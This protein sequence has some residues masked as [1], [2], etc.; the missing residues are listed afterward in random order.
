MKNWRDTNP[1]ARKAEMKYLF[2]IGLSPV[3]FI[4][5]SR[6][7]K[8]QVKAYSKGRWKLAGFK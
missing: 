8:A 7:R 5:G 6:H 3:K 4:H 2:S 1:K